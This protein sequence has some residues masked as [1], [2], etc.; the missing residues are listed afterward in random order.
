[1]GFEDC[2]IVGGESESR[3][4][5][6]FSFRRGDTEERGEEEGERGDVA[7]SWRGG[8]R[9]NGGMMVVER[10][11][12]GGKGDIDLIGELSIG[13]KGRVPEV[14]RGD[15]WGIGIGLEGEEEGEK[16]GEEGDEASRAARKDTGAKLG[17]LDDFVRG[18]E[19]WEVKGE[20]K[21]LACE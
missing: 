17:V 10:R 18:D 13:S 21:G 8:L 7:S 5:D 16:E 14:R 9:D 11:G 4:G 12:W 15:F 6:T 19:S 20:R 3:R 1:M 2:G